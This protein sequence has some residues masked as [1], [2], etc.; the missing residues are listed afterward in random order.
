MFDVVES[1]WD[2]NRSKT[3]LYRNGVR[4][5]FIAAGPHTVRG[6]RSKALVNTTDLYA[7][8]LHVAGLRKPK[9]ARDSYSFKHTLYGAPHSRRRVNVAEQFATGEVVG[10]TVGTAGANPFFNVD[11]R[12][13]SDGRFRLIARSVRVGPDFQCND[14]A[15]EPVDCLRDGIFDKEVNLELYDLKTDAL[16]N[17]NL[18]ADPRSMTKRQLYGFMN[19][20]R[21]LNRVSRRANFFQNG[22][23]CKPKE[24]L[25]PLLDD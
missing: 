16:E 25:A 19:V 15:V 10:G 1:P 22:R 5:P 24:I 8:A 23:V 4:V 7:T 20:C 12:V 14:G 3:T 13:V 6:K 9:S 11:G 17:T 18:L 2:N 21:G